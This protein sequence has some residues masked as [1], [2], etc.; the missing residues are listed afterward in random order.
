MV[1][2]CF[3]LARCHVETVE[4]IVARLAAP[5][6]LPGSCGQCGAKAGEG[7]RRSDRGVECPFAKGNS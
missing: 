2:W 6:V 1:A 3:E 4:S 5:E 7:C